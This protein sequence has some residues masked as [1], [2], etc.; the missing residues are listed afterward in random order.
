MYARTQEHVLGEDVH[1]IDTLRAEA[2]GQ[3]VVT[4]EV[5]LKRTTK[6]GTETICREG[7]RKHGDVAETTFQWLICGI[8]EPSVTEVIVIEHTKDV[9]HFVLKV[10]CGDQGVQEL[11]S[12]LDHGVDFTTTSSEVGIVVESLPEVVD[13]L[14]SGLSTSINEDT[15]FG[16]INLS[17]IIKCNMC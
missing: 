5:L 15:N 16:L 7:T 4:M 2:I 6:D 3:R 10:L 8:R 14:V 9:R 17:Q 11:L 13:R 12:T 1:A